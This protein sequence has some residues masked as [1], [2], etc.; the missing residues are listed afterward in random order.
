[1]DERL[2]AFNHEVAS[3]ADDWF[4]NPRNAEVYGR[5]IAAIEARRAYRRRGGIDESAAP[6][7]DSTPR[8]NGAPRGTKADRTRTRVLDA[9][10]KVFSRKGYPGTRLSDIAAEAEMHPG[11][12]YYH[13]RTREELVDEVL[14]VG[15][16]R[17]DRFVRNRLA[18]LPPD[19][20]NL[21]RLRELITAHAEMV[22][23]FG[24][25]TSAMI[26]IIGQ[27][28]EDVHQRRLHDQRQ[29]GQYWRS[30]FKDAQTDGELRTDVDLSAM[31]MLI[32]GALN[33]APDWYRPGEGLHPAA[34]GSELVTVF[35]TGLAAGCAPAT[36]LPGALPA[37]HPA[38][39]GS[40]ESGGPPREATRARILDAAASELREHDYAGT[41]LSNVAERAGLRPGSL[42]YYFQSREELLAT[43]L[44]EAWEE[45]NILVREAVDGLPAKSSHLDRL[46]AAIRAHLLS[47]LSNHTCTSGL[48]RIVEQLPEQVRHPSLAGQ[49]SFTAYWRQLLTE[50][51]DAGEIRT[52]V[53][54]PAVANMLI[55]TINWA[56][57]WY[58]PGGRLELKTL[59][60]QF[61]TVIFYGLAATNPANTGNRI[62][63]GTNHLRP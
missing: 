56:V 24:D 16:G 36:N 49:R 13:F 35:L 60:T 55:G 19:A 51:Q 63:H 6:G 34:L 8:G 40:P 53:D 32:L 52:D 39:P 11:S 47:A 38:G 9:A 4:D 23:E 59:S 3:A 20:T 29:Y 5:L 50:A 37:G 54:V 25:Y 18:A 61:T 31:M 46:S 7:G 27:V 45:A 2:A 10:A 22:L 12:L 42:Y 33:S 62:D 1:M 57:E 41:R 44:G 43:L 26:R 17:V 30:L 14:R 15:Q 58:Q 28:P 48:L 21:A